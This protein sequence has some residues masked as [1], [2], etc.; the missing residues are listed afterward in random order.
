VSSHRSKQ[1]KTVLASAGLTAVSIGLA[2]VLGE[3]MLRLKNA[4]M[5]NYDVEMWK[6]ANTLKQK[7]TNPILDFTHIPSKTAILQK[8]KISLNEYGLRGPEIKTEDVNRR[9][10]FL[11]GSITLG[12]GVDEDEVTTSI[13]SQMLNQKNTQ[14]VEVINAGV[15]NYNAERYTERFFKQLTELQ[16]TDI[17]VQYFLRDAENLQPSEENMILSNSQLALTLWILQQRTFGSK[18]Q[19]SIRDHYQRVYDKKSF[20]FDKM[21]NSLSRLAQYAKTNNIR[22]FMLMTPDIHDLKN[23]AFE[24]IHTTMKGF[25]ESNGYIYVDALDKLRGIS[26]EDLYAM[27]GD[28]HPNALGH[29][30][31]AE[32]IAPALLNHQ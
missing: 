21:K 1:W 19:Q 9:I 15:G 23:Y 8:K 20:G 26:A 24:D 18:G 10:L 17:V 7:S 5:E 29:R 32:T 2:L 22:L 13:V 4:S 6:Y 14:I 25:A 27:P 31:M 28:P 16:P 11:G 12:W 3:G 30:L